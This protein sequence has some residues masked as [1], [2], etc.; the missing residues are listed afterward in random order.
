MLTEEQQQT[1]DRMV[2]MMTAQFEAANAKLARMKA[3]EPQMHVESP[4]TQANRAAAMRHNGELPEGIM[5][6]KDGK[7]VILER[8]EAIIA[9]KEGTATLN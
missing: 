7:V 8:D 9:L 2:A 1:L 6:M 5:V 3:L 4:E